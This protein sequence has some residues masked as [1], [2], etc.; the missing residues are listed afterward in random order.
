MDPHADPESWLL[1]N[2][3]FVSGGNLR[4]WRDQFCP[5]E[6]AAEARGDGD[7][8]DDDAGRVIAG[9]AAARLRGRSR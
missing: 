5:E 7:A 1:E 4:W 2:P 8:Y 9:R 6:R 3:G